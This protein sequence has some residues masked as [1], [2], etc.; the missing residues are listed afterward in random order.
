MGNVLK[1]VPRTT[2]VE[3]IRNGVITENI[4][5]ALLA[6]RDNLIESKPHSWDL[7]FV[8]SILE[9]PNPSEKR[10]ST[11]QIA[12]LERIVGHWK[13]KH[14]KRF[15]PRKDASENRNNVVWL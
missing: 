1:F 8:A 6:E 3:E 10:L 7:K 12:Q 11:K 2:F 13:Y 15:E 5:K 4:R 14:G 9:L